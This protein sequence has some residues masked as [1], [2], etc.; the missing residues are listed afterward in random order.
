MLKKFED[1]RFAIGSFFFIIGSLLLVAGVFKGDAD[2]SSMNLWT[3]IGFVAF[4]V[5]ALFLSTRPHR[6]AS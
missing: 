5:L 2:D 3:G 1:L 4:A 6:A